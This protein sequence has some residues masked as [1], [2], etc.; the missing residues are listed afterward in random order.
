MEPAHASDQHGEEFHAIGVY[1][2]APV[3]DLAQPGN[4]VQVAAW[5]LGEKYISV[6]VFDFYETAEAAAVAKLFPSLFIISAVIH[7]LKPLSVARIIASPR[8]HF[9][10]LFQSSCR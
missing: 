5:R 10:L 4:N 9:L 7:S 1:C 8:N 6:I 3:I 2:K